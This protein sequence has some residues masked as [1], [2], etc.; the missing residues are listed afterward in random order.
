MKNR[1]EKI[2]TIL[3]S[4]M[5]AITLIGFLYPYLTVSHQVPITTSTL[6]P[7]QAALANN[8]TGSNTTP[9]LVANTSVEGSKVVLEDTK[10]TVSQVVSDTI[11]KIAS[12]VEPQAP[13]ILSTDKV[14]A[15]VSAYDYIDN[16]QK[17]SDDQ[18]YVEITSLAKN[19]CGDSS[20]TGCY[21]VQ[22]QT[23]LS[24]T[25]S[26][27]NQYFYYLYPVSFGKIDYSSEM[28]GFLANNFH[29]NSWVEKILTV[30]GNDGIPEK[31]YL[32]GYQSDDGE[33]LN[34]KISGTYKITSP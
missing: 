19:Q 17:K 21:S 25:Y 9:S 16:K 29:D 12:S 14:Y 3:L 4:L 27:N 28:D 18:T 26:L 7:S 15:V 11:E 20:T 31:Y 13:V 10:S 34:Y 22:N 24:G 6:T 30:K 1:K 2:F 32:Y 33:H 5:A 8:T 23:A